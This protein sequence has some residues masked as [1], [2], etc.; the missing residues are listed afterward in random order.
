[1]EKSEEPT[2]VPPQASAGA[3]PTK[4]TQRWVLPEG[5]RS[6]SPPSGPQRGFGSLEAYPAALL[7]GSHGQNIWT[8]SGLSGSGC[9]P[10]PT[11]AAPP[12]A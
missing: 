2:S 1:M 6:P 8:R 4:R 11:A 10:A 7:Q 5:L 3:D 12:P 9:G